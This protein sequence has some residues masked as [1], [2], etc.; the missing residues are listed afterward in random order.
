MSDLN[1]VTVKVLDR[2]YKVK[3]PPDQAQGLYDAA[4]AVSLQMRNVRQTGHISTTERVAVV[5]ALNLCY[6]LIQLKKESTQNMLRMQS[7]INTLQQKI[8]AFMT[9]EATEETTET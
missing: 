3:C 5:T 8:S 9:L 4:D 2:L 7:N 1:I 6:E